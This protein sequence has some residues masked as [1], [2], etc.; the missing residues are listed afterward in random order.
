MATGMIA[1]AAPRR[2]SRVTLKAKKASPRTQPL[3]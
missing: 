1:K 2:A 3:H